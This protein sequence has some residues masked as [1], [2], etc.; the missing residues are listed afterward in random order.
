MAKRGALIVVEGLDRAGKSTQC[1]LLV[2]NLEARGHDVRYVKFPDRSTPTGTIINQYLTGQ[3][4]QDDHVIHLLFA[5]NR[6]E[7]AARIT[8]DIAAGT[9]VIVDRYCYSGCVYS[10]A[11]DIPGIDLEWARWPDVGLPRPDVCIFLELSADTAAARAGFGGERYE[12]QAMQARVR[13][14]FYEL[15]TVYEKDIFHVIDGGESRD[16]V[17][18]NVLQAVLA[19]LQQIDT[20]ASDQALGTIQPLRSRSHQS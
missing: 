13:A 6:W 8:S 19:Q 9:T 7:A 17:E 16:T 18:D 10:A 12:N 1:G 3:A 4:Q 2:K 5:A 15:R 20:S 11:K 14:L